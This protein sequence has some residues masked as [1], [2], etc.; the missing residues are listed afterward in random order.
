MIH[1]VVVKGSIKKYFSTNDKGSMSYVYLRDALKDLSIIYRDRKDED[2]KYLLEFKN[3][4]KRVDK[5]AIKT[6][7]WFDCKKLDKKIKQISILHDRYRTDVSELEDEE[8][9]QESR[10][11]AIATG[12]VSFSYEKLIDEFVNVFFVL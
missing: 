1:F 4:V 5:Y 9:K 2:Y 10:E 12:N 6:W 11:L 7:K 8:S 3:Y